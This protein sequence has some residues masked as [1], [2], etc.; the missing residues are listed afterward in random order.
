M[1]Q[2]RCRMASTNWQTFS[3]WLHPSAGW[4]TASSDPVSIADFTALLNS[5]NGTYGSEPRLRIRGDMVRMTSELYSS[6]GDDTFI[7]DDFTELQWLRVLAPQASAQQLTAT[8][9]EPADG[10]LKTQ[11]PGAV[12]QLT[13][14]VDIERSTA[15]AGYL[16]RAAQGLSSIP[17]QNPRHVVLWHFALL[18]IIAR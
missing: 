8:L 2:P 14:Q 4:R 15:D 3:A 12:R 18:L 16:V 10:V 17:I 7:E 6:L 1:A 11:A 5:A 9:A 13:V